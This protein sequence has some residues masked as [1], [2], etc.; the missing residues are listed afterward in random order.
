MIRPSHLVFAA[1]A[2]AALF[3]GAASGAQ[4]SG[5]REIRHE[6]AHTAGQ[7]IELEFPIGELRIVGYE[8]TK[9]EVDIRAECRWS[10]SRCEAR[11]ERLAV[12]DRS[13]DRRMRLEVD[14]GG[15]FRGSGLELRAEI[16]VPSSAPLAVEMGIGELNIR[17]MANDLHVDLGIGEVKVSVPETS[18]AGVTVDAGIGE[19]DL[20]GPS[21]SVRH[22]RPM[23]VGSHLSWNAGEGR[24]QIDVS[25][26]IGE[27]KV[28][29]D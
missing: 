14:D 21:R 12:D 29:L 16:R 22:A 6:F 8:G 20:H 3:L 17:D 1:A 13:S 26:G 18:A 11:L 28:Y 24:A 19:S 7:P 10:S 25:V 4:A 9:V 15:F 5:R 27:A 2:S 23:L